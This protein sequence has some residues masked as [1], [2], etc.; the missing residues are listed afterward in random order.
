MQLE[1]IKQPLYFKHYD[2]CKKVLWVSISYN[3][4]ECILSVIFPPFCFLEHSQFYK[5]CR[6]L[7]PHHLRYFCSTTRL[8]EASGAQR[9][10]S[11]C[12]SSFLC[13]DL[14]HLKRTTLLAQKSYC[15]KPSYVQSDRETT[16]YRESDN[17]AVSLLNSNM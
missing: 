3:L 9:A 17:T 14:L 2:M 10:D 7:L 13:S 12:S 16:Q 4:A 6:A 11:N 8:V 15:L 5:V 1:L